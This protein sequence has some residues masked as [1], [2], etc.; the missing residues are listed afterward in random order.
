MRLVV[1]P[2]K[3]RL[4]LD[5]RKINEVTVKD[6]NPLPNIESIF[7]RLPKAN[8]I[9]KIYLKDAYWQIG[10]EEKSKAITAFTI[11]GQP[12]YQFTVMPFGLCTAPQ[13]MCRLIDSIIPPELRH[14][15][16]G[17]LDD[18]CVVSNTFEEHISILMRLAEQFKKCYL[19]LNIE[20]SQFCV[21]G[22]PYL[23]Y[24]IGDGGVATDP[25]KIESIFNWL[26]PKSLKQV[27]GF[28]GIAGWYRQFIANFADI[29][30]PITEVLPN[31]RKF[32]SDAMWNYKLLRLSQI[33]VV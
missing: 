22:V 8:I 25:Q 1:K 16:F 5:A 28:L 9:S 7:A 23:G 26:M 27:R 13:T 18:V 6:A 19:T 12:L 29:T 20:K 10:L 30:H 15:V 3:V 33:I 2:E 24:N 17:Y 14:S 21:K 31:K 4:C 32:D 11:P